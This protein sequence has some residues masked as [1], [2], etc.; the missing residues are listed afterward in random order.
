MQWGC[1]WY[2]ILL[3][4]IWHHTY[5]FFLSILMKKKIVLY[6]VCDK[7]RWSSMLKCSAQICNYS[8][9]FSQIQN[10]NWVFAYMTSWYLHWHTTVV[11]YFY[12]YSTAVKYLYTWPVGICI[13]TWLQSGIFLDTRLQSSICMYSVGYFHR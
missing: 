5:A 7:T 1:C 2:L 9:V 11:G 4:I 6:N 12:R 8:R 13:S 3:K 10:C